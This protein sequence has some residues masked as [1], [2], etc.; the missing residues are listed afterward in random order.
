MLKYC[1]NN[2]MIGNYYPFF[3]SNFN[4][5]DSYYLYRIF[6]PSLS[7]DLIPY[8]SLEKISEKTKTE[9]HE[10]GLDIISV[11]LGKKASGNKA[12]EFIAELVKKEGPTSVEENGT[13]FPLLEMLSSNILQK[14]LIINLRDALRWKIYKFTPDRYVDVLWTPSKFVVFKIKED[15][16]NKEAIYLEPVGVYNNMDVNLSNPLN[17]DLKNIDCPKDRFTGKSKASDLNRLL[18]RLEW[19]SFERKELK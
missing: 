13:N 15:S 14:T 17:I 5:S 10:R 12:K 11:C 1:I 8:L 7:P 19:S 2:S 9:P 3:L 18:K 16:Q 4:L 6:S